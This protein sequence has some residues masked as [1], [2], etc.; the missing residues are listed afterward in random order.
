M[1]KINILVANIQL[2]Q[3]FYRT[4][5]A[6]VPKT[7]RRN[8]NFMVVVKPVNLEKAVEVEAKIYGKITLVTKKTLEPGKTINTYNSFNFILNLN[9][10]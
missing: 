8:H 9:T 1:F 2:L 5:V 3:K 7:V 6:F 4:Y 10:I